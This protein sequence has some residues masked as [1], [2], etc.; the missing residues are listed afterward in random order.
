MTFGDISVYF[1]LNFY[2]F[3]DNDAF[4][5]VFPE[6]NVPKDFNEKFCEG[7]KST[8]EGGEMPH[9]SVDIFDIKES[10]KSTLE[11]GMPP[12][13]VD[14][15]PDFVRIITFL[16]NEPKEKRFDILARLTQ[17]LNDIP[18]IKRVVISSDANLSPEDEDEFTDDYDDY[19]YDDE[20]WDQILG[21]DKLSLNFPAHVDGFEGECFDYSVYFTETPGNEQVEL[22]QNAIHDYDFKLTGDDYIGYVSVECKAGIVTI[23]LDLGNTV[24]ENEN[25]IIHG[26]LLAMNDVPGI[27][28]VILNE[29]Y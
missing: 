27:E 6:N 4:I 25:K 17:A 29:G 28:K 26:I 3:Y 20:S 7:M 21:I 5:Y 9:I 18:G 13:S 11:G 16:H 2:E 12:I 14:I 23:Y 1:P 15:M 19:E 8:F 24:P 22:I 10:L